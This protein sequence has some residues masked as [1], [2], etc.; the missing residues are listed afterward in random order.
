M[1]QFHIQPD[2]EIPVSTQLFNQIWFAI[3]SRQIP[4]GHRLPSTRQL[5][6][7]TGLHRNTISKVYDRL[8]AVGLVEAQVGSGIYVRDLAQE[9]AVKTNSGNSAEYPA[10]AYA[11]VQQSLEALLN[12]GYSLNQARELFISEIDRRLSAG[13]QVL[14]TV[15]R[16]DLG[17]G[18]LMVQE[19]QQS[20]LIPVRLVTLDELQTVLSQD[21]SGTVVTS[22]YFTG[23]AE[24][25]A[26]PHSVRVIPIDI[27]N[28]SR[29]LQVVKSLPKG[30]N[31]GLVSL[32]AGTL[33][34]A[35]VLIYSLRG[36]EL[37]IMTAQQQDTYKLKALVRNT[38]TIITDQAS[39][40]I[41]KATVLA[42]RGDIIRLPQIVSCQNYID[43]QSINLLKRELGLD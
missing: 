18:E 11:L 33:E 7:Q 8:E 39:F 29:E 38:H 20:L 28:Y 37:L 4:P 42:A 31:L 21:N 17:A 23:Q 25:I 2:S 40:A 41:V 12:L 13:T 27:Y 26:S 14:V 19:L 10:S 24:E 5:A 16:H 9:S 22:R 30:S 35:R 43:S 32:S 36:E 34:V 1:V 6:L 3:A 15:P